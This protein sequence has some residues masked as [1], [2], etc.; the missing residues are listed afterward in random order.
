[1]S[2]EIISPERDG[3]ERWKGWGGE[4]KGMGRRGERDGEKR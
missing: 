1:M 2:L 4:V 3:E